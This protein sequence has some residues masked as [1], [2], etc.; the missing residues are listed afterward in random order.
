M[1][2]Q[3][4]NLSVFYE[5]L[6][7]LYSVSFTIQAHEFVSILGPN[8]AGKS[9]LLQAIAGLHRNA[10]GRII[11]DGSPIQGTPSH[12]VISRGIALIPEEGWLY[13]MMSVAENLLMGAYSPRARPKAKISLDFVYNLFPR[14]RERR[15]QMA[16]TLSGGERQMLAVGRGLMGQPKLLVLDE[17]SLGLAPIVIR[18]IMDTLEMLNKE[19]G[20]TILMT[21][22]NIF[23]ALR[24]S[25][26]GYVMEN[27]RIT[28][29]GA[30][31]DLLANDHIKKE[32][33]GI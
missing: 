2:L 19:E 23:Q 1:L 32:Y 28:L 4:E 5:G 10:Q 24:I 9:T 27:G 7:A 15:N 25:H 22:Q 13:P 16:E 17:P 14:L 3:V 26:R 8:G 18:D 33:L 11:F 31:D 6:Q 21:E 12:L 29:E 20:I 30:S